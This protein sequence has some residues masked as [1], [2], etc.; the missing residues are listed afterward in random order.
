LAAVLAI[1]AAFVGGWALLLA[2]PAASF[3][4]VALAYTGLGPRLLGK[5]L[6]GTISLWAVALHL[7]Y[8]ALT[9]G[10]WHVQ[11]LLSKAEPAQEVAP[12]LWVGRRPF[13]RE[14]PATV[15]LVVDLTGEF[16]ELAGV[17]AG[18]NYICLPTLDAMTPRPVDLGRAVETAAKWDGP[19]Y[20]HCALGH[21]RTG[22]FAAAVLVAR[23]VVPDVNAAVNLLRAA[24]P[25]IRLNPA[26]LQCLEALVT[27]T[28]R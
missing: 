16:R 12:G 26:Q 1:D 18:R 25:G 8:F 15:T 11:R 5:R 17:R 14:V 9:W 24:R 28:N 2:W 22:M 10:V 13:P 19:M 6:D 27:T 3:L 7:P 20:V 21:G 4:V 23:G